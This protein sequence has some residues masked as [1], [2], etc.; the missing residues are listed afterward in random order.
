MEEKLEIQA[1]RNIFS[2]GLNKRWHMTTRFQ[3]QLI[4]AGDMLSEHIH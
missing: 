3:Q 4:Q 1:G 2:M